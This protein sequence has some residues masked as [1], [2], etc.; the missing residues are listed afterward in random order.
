M[1]LV[2]GVPLDFIYQLLNRELPTP[3]SSNRCADA[4]RRNANLGLFG[5]T[6]VLGI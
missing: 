6:R 3:S 2:A 4:V 5:R 1:G